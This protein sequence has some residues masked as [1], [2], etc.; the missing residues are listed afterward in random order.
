MH[1]STVF[2]PPIT[3]ITHLDP[4]VYKK[5]KIVMEK[6]RLYK[7]NTAFEGFAPSLSRITHF[8]SGLFN[9]NVLNGE[10]RIHRERKIT[11]KNTKIDGFAPPITRITHIDPDCSSAPNITEI[12]H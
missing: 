12:L 1:C 9:K 8:K 3:R 4:D 7:K 10:I 6:F 2:A 11:L 5:K